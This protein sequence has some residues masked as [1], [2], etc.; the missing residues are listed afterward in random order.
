MTLQSLKIDKYFEYLDQMLVDGKFMKLTLSKKRDKASTLKNIFVTRLELK[1]GPHL[2]FTY[3]YNTNDTVKNF[4]YEEGIN[5][6]RQHVMED[7]FYSD[8]FG[9]GVHWAL[10]IFPHGKVNLKSTDQNELL[11]VDDNHN[12]QKKRYVPTQGHGSY[13]L[14][15]GIFDRHMQPKNT[16]MDK[17][18]Q[19]NRYVEILS[20][21]ISALPELGEYHVWDM[22]SGK[23][24]LTFALYDY[25]VNE[26]GKHTVMTGVEFREDLVN[27]CN[28]F[29]N[30][31][32]FVD[33]KFVQGNI[34]E[35]E[36]E[37]TNILIALH[38]CDTATDDAIY[39][40]IQQNSQLIVCA[41]CCHKQVRRDMGSDHEF[42][43]ITQHGILKERQAEIVTDSIRSLI[44]EAWGYK[45]KVFE[46]I[47]SEHTAKNVMIIGRKMHFSKEVF[48]QKMQQ[49]EELKKQFGLTSHHLQTKLA[50][51]ND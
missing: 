38:A 30:R 8:L 45:T 25:M 28:Q 48:D 44:L 11:K 19:I 33:L 24:Y 20:P 13:M 21:E 3:R 7:F 1:A 34:Q 43:A 40:G 2:S 37:K 51:K 46:F 39:R 6:L 4:S 49:V 12:R 15:L 22:G 26:M 9:V 5:M 42:G 16:S 35:V 47:S 18:K 41:P 36:M 23:G 17:F 32:K 10:M 50:E 14:D 29:S 27:K 31:A